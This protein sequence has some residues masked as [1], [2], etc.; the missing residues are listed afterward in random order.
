MSV[1]LEQPEEGTGGRTTEARLPHPCKLNDANSA[2]AVAAPSLSNFR[3]VGFPI[4]L[5]ILMRFR[6]QRWDRVVL[7]LGLAVRVVLASAMSSSYVESCWAVDDL[8]AGGFGLRFG[9]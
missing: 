5:Q 4:R 2:M 8:E 9:C 6:W 7:P 1:N 3:R